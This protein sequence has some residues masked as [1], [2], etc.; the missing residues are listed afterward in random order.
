M[1]PENILVKNTK[2]QNTIVTFIESLGKF[3]D[4]IE[5]N[6]FFNCS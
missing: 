1:N 3:C 5:G 2:K 4:F 6:N